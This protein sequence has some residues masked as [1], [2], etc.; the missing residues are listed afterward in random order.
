MSTKVPTE[1]MIELE[2]L[3]GPL[4]DEYL[5]E[6]NQVVLKSSAVTTADASDKR[7]QQP[8]STSSASTLATTI[9]ADGHFDVVVSLSC[10]GN[11]T[12]STAATT[13]SRR[14]KMKYLSESYEVTPPTTIQKISDYNSAPKLQ[15]KRKNYVSR[16]TMQRQART[17]KSHKLSFR[18]CFFVKKFKIERKMK[19]IREKA[20][21]ILHM[22]QQ[23][24]TAAQLVSRYHTIGRCNNYAVLQSIPCS[25]ECKIVKKILL[26]HPLSYALTATADVPAVDTLHLPV[27][28]LK[29]PFVAP[30]NIQTIEAFMNR[31]GYQGVVDKKK[32]VI[33]YPRF[34]KLII[35]DLIKK[36]PNIPQRI[37]EDYHSIKDDI[38]L[39][40][41][42]TTG[43]VLVRGMLI[44]DEFLTEKICA[45]DDYKENTPRS[46][47]TPTLTTSSPQ[48]KKRKQSVGELSSPE[49]S[50]KITIRQKHV[51]KGEKDKQTYDDADDSDD[52]LEPESHKENPEHV[53]DDEKVDEKKDDEMGSLETR[54]EEMQTPIA[55]TPRTPRTILSLD[56]NITQELTDT[57]SLPTVT[58]SKDPHPKRRISIKYNHLLSALRRMCRRQG[59][60]IKNMERKATDD[61]IEN[62]LKPSIVATIIKDRDAFHSKV[63]DLVSQELNPQ[64]PK[65]IE[66][67]FKNYVQKNVIQVHPTITTSTKITSSAD[68][69]QQ[70][71]LKMKRSLQDQAN[72]L[73]LHDDHQEDDAPPEGEKRV[74]RHKT[75]NSS[76]SAREE[77]V[78]DEDEVISKDE[79]PELIIE[80]QNVDKPVPTIFDRAR[81][82]AT[83]NDMLSNQFKNVE[84]YAYHLEQATNFYRESDSLEK[85]TRGHKT[86]TEEKKYIL[87][88]HKKHVKRCLEADLAEKMN[89]WVRKEFKN[90]NE[91]AW[92]S[93]Q[94]WKD[95]WH[96]RVYKQNQRR[97]KNNPEDYF[98]NHMITEVVR[99]TID[100]PHGLDFIEQIIVMR[101]NDKPDSFLKLTSTYEPYS[102]VD[103]PNTGLIYLN[104]KNEKQVMYLVKI[105]KFC[106]A[107]LEKVLKVAKLKIF[108]SEPWKKRSLLG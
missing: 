91:D 96:K 49:K 9:S 84:E 37:D 38:P 70:L 35:A 43:N 97:V 54:T 106:D 58:T 95:S 4:F 40:S 102:I 74:K 48:R 78:I 42:Y 30:V 14:Y 63:P 99:I 21:Q 76:K 57:V 90:F 11:V 87:S 7:Q 3:F 85:Q 50:L 46:H 29:N 45:T 104:S 1:D 59:Y 67:L 41:V 66:E 28:T 82:E 53:D 19:S 31:V 34:I 72:D 39:V 107:T 27:E 33:Q 105:V 32:E 61:L 92:L 12:A 94:H 98:S 26:D 22:A 23:V 6:E 60:M 24:I 10:S 89:R 44:L 79:T 77:T 15:S 100:Q 86:N 64:A 69:Q 55:T 51:D 20:N 13:L 75:S 17:G 65:I 56:K 101:E 18:K 71:Y 93:I 68:L 25:P 8:D 80:F 73:A 83:L 36:F 81:M 16:E 2:N 47:R 5:N 103:K 108:Q 88:L 62:N 52:R